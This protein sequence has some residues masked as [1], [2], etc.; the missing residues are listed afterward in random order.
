MSATRR[1]SR[2][3]G[4]LS[5]FDIDEERK[6]TFA[7]LKW[8]MRDE[9]EREWRWLFVAT[10]GV[11]SSAEVDFIFYKQYFK[12]KVATLDLKKK[13]VKDFLYFYAWDMEL[14]L[15]VNLTSRLNLS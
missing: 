8:E 15:G 14:N 10:D 6:R 1:A 11:D 12:I 5:I 7:G 2:E 3:L 4:N 9:K 13:L